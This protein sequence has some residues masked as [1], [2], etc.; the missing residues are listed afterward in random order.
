MLEETMLGALGL[1]VWGGRYGLPAMSKQ[2]Q[3]YVLLIIWGE[4]NTVL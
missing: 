1:G 4:E 2:L 3:T